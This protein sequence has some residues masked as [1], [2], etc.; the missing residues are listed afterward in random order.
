MNPLVIARTIPEVIAHALPDGAIVELRRGRGPSRGRDRIRLGPNHV[1][2]IVIHADGSIEDLG[3][4]PNLLTT[5]GRD[6]VAAALGSQGQNAGGSV[7]ANTAT[8]TSATSLTNTN[9]AYTT[10]Q[11]KGWT[12]VAEESTNTPVF[13]NI[14]TNS[15]TVLTI[16][17]W[18]NADDSAGNTPGST[19]NYF[20][21]PSCR[22]RYIGLTTDAAAAAAGDTTLASEITTG[23]VARALGTYAHT[24]GTSTLTLSKTFAVTGSFTAI[25]KGGLF[26]ASNTTAGGIMVFETVLN[27][28]ATVVNGDSLAVTWTITLS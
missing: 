13:G 21:I 23:G 4:S 5:A 3:V 2:A 22:P 27:A 25:H 19:A 18:R 14:G 26:T 1:S 16:D 28:D 12:V 6:L 20:I 8:A 10:D 17:A 24:G 11:F 15:A 9:A 7:T